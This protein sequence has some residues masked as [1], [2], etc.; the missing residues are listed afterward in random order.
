MSLVK[1]YRAGDPIQVNGGNLD[2]RWGAIAVLG[3]SILIQGLE[4]AQDLYSLKQLLPP[5]MVC[6]GRVG[7]FSQGLVGALHA[8]LEALP[9]LTPGGIQDA[10]SRFNNRVY[11]TIEFSDLVVAVVELARSP[12]GEAFEIVQVVG[13]VR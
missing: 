3:A 12:A 10:G 5:E 7:L 8:C 2:G 4:F 13:E 9:R 6:L 11:E 1:R